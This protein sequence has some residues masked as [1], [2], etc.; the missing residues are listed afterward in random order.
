MGSFYV[1]PERTL[2]DPPQAIHSRRLL[3]SYADISADEMYWETLGNAH[4]CIRECSLARHL[5][6]SHALQAVAGNNIWPCGAVDVRQR[7]ACCILAATTYFPNL[8]SI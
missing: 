4:Y 3:F 8:P 2:F 6:W 1:S 5:I 7:L